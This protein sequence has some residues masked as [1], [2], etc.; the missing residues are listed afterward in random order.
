MNKLEN[1]TK[2]VLIILLAAGLAAQFYINHLSL[3][4]KDNEI[5]DLQYDLY[6]LAKSNEIILL[7]VKR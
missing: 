1:Y 3:I 2:S 4:E 5:S 7:N 6:D